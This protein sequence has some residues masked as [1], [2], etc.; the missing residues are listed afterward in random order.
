MPNNVDGNVP[1][2]SESD[3]PDLLLCKLFG[4]ESSTLFGIQEVTKTI[5]KAA[6]TTGGETMLLNRRGNLL[7]VFTMFIALI[8]ALSCCAL[9]QSGT[10]AQAGNRCLVVSVNRNTDRA[11]LERVLNEQAS[12]VW[13]YAG[14]VGLPNAFAQLVFERSR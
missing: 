3:I 7:L 14:N 4:V 8:T 13:R 5:V 11:E 1:L 12:S 10:S 2:I 6:L 9:I